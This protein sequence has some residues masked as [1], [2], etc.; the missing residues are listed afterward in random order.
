[1]RTGRLELAIPGTSLGH[2]NAAGVE[3]EVVGKLSRAYFAAALAVESIAGVPAYLR[4]D[5]S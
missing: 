3:A 1:M 5:L 2:R 4:A